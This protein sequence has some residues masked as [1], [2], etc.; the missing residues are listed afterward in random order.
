MEEV[1]DIDFLP[2]FSLEGFPNRDSN[3]YTELYGIREAHTVLRGTLRYR[4]KCTSS[5]YQTLELKP[6]LLGALSTG[7]SDTMQGML[8]LGLLDQKP[9]PALHPKGPELNWVCMSVHHSKFV[10]MML[11]YEV[12][13]KTKLCF[14]SYFTWITEIII[15]CERYLGEVREW[16]GWLAVHLKFTHKRPLCVKAFYQ[17][18]DCC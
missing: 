6:V 2:G 13:I 17:N 7:F 16:N 5:Y 9:H 10:K 3:K 4:G 11:S 12:E 8:L 1:K 18:C 14:N 15:G